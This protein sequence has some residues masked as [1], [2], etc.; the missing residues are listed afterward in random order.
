ML[1]EMRKHLRCFP[2]SGQHGKIGDFYVYVGRTDRKTL[3]A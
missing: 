3:K 1:A 2:M